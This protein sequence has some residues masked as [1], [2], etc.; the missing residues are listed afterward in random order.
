[1]IRWCY[2]IQKNPM[3]TPGNRWKESLRLPLQFIGLLWAIH[4]F[5]VITRIDLGF[6]GIYPHKVIGLKGILFAPLVHADWQHLISNS[7]PFLVLTIILQF[8]YRRVA[9]RSFLMIYFLTGV[10]VW[11]F[12]RQQ[13]FHIG[14]SGVVYGLVAF[15]FWSG[16]FR[17]SLQ[18]IVLALIVTFL[19]SGYF[20]GILPNQEG[21]S[22]ESHL[23][24]GLVG[25]FTSYWYREE[26]E[27]DELPE[28]PSWEEDSQEEGR[29]FLDRDAFEKTKEQRRQEREDDQGHSG[30]GWFSNHT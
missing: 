4:L 28:K 19:Y 21:I 6:L 11:L 25:I 20:M 29:Y 14:A 24:G 18:S 16:V 15:V 22:W 26:I 8:F 3:A 17:R 12:G 9:I 23:M 5:Q 27:Q 1:M 7:V 10:A 2:T 13:V 30:G